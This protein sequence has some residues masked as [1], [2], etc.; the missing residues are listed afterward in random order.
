MC[1]IASFR[2]RV[3]PGPETNAEP[4]R[5]EHPDEPVTIQKTFEPALKPGWYRL[6]IRYGQE[7]LV[8]CVVEL[9]FEDGR[10]ELRRVPFIA[11]NTVGCIVRWPLGV[12]GVKFHL[13]GSQ[14]PYRNGSVVVA[15]APVAL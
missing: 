12:A 2:T 9:Q 8:D 1:H 7:G 15:P 3:P 10:S 14:P 6:E 4:I 5:I 13:T 11:R